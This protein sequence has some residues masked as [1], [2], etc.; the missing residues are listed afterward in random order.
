M[1]AAGVCRG[2]RRAERIA[3]IDWARR[4]KRIVDSSFVER[5]RHVS[6]GAEHAVFHDQRRGLAIKATHP[7]RY[8]HSTHEEGAS[9]T[10]LEYLRRLAWHNAL[11]GDD[12]RFLG[13]ILVED[14]V[15]VVTSQP[16]IVA[17]E[18]HFTTVEEIDKYFDALGFRHVELV[19][20]V[21]LYFSSELCVVIADAHQQNV[22]MAE[23]GHL[24]PIDVVVGMPGKRL[25]ER[26]QGA[27]LV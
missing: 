14:S 5:F 27:L 18:K 19:V 20:G 11:F 22:I 13:L 17:D 23:G 1:L 26:L 8:G 24:V 12:I 15:Q 25:L 3:L 2:I 9:A 10:P 4:H 6:S 21:Q 16:W 7:N